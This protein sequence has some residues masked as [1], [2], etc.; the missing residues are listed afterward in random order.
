[1]PIPEIE[2]SYEG[3]SCLPLEREHYFEL[4]LELVADGERISMG[5]CAEVGDFYVFGGPSTRY[6][7]VT[8]TESEARSQIEL[9]RLRL[10]GTLHDE[11]IAHARVLTHET[12]DGLRSIAVHAHAQQATPLGIQGGLLE[13]LGRHLA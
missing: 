7:A 9:V 13:V 8:V 1:M 5:Q 2:L 3:R 12:P 4:E 6:H 10:C 11:L